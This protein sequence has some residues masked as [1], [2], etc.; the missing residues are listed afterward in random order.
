MF[1]HPSPSSSPSF[2]YPQPV[3]SS[4]QAKGYGVSQA[5]GAIGCILQTPRAAYKRGSCGTYGKPG[6]QDPTLTCSQY[7]KPLAPNW[8]GSRKTHRE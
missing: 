8:P 7:L 3:S 6:G 4:E 1:A 5:K 2:P